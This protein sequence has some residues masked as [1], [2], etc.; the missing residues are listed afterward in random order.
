MNMALSNFHGTGEP[1][2][3]ALGHSGLE[4]VRW[5]LL[6]VQLVLPTKPSRFERRSSDP[7]VDLSLSGACQNVGNCARPA[8]YMGT[9][10]VWHRS[11]GHA[12]IGQKSSSERLI[13]VCQ[14]VKSIDTNE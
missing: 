9:V 6:L 8:R 13:A 5:P 12:P 3:Q 4:E 10:W 1:I 2:P 14:C 7:I 11:Y